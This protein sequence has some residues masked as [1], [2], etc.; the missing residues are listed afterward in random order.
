MYSRNVLDIQGL[1]RMKIFVLPG[2]Q[3]VSPALLLCVPRRCFCTAGPYPVGIQGWKV[4][5][6]TQGLYY[7]YIVQLGL[8]LNTKLDLDHPPPTT[9]NFSKG[10]RLG[11][12]LRF[13]M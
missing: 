6:G 9:T 2:K 10:S 13:Y 7:I 3:I 12:R 4:T 11:R 8:K 1:N 5:F